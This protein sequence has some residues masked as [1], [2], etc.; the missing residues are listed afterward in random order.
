MS[1]VTDSI[2]AKKEL[3]DLLAAISALSIE[4]AQA[5]QMHLDLEFRTTNER[6]KGIGDV[7]KFLAVSLQQSM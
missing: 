2:T 4:A 3:D 6:I 1:K 7:L 5:R